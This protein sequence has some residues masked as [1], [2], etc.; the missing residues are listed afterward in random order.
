MLYVV[1]LGTLCNEGECRVVQ[2]TCISQR[3]FLSSAPGCSAQH[4]HVCHSVGVF[5]RTNQGIGEIRKSLKTGKMPMGVLGLHST[6]M[7]VMK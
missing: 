7:F 2:T 4:T 1:K 6:Q 3:R 5:A